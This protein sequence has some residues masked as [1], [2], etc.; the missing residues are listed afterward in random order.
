MPA[1]VRRL[2]TELKPSSYVLTIAPN[3]EALTFR[4]TV[5]VRLKKTGRPSQRITFHQHG[6]TVDTAR[7]T[8]FDKKGVHDVPVKRINNQK[9]LDEVRLHTDMMVYSGEYEVQMEFHGKILRNLTGLYPSYFNVDGKEHIL[10]TTQFESHYARQMFPCIDEPEAKAVFT[11]M[12]I[13]PEDDVVLS[14][15]PIAS[16]AAYSGEL[17]P[18]PAKALRSVTFQQTPRM[19][20]YLLAMAIG[21]MHSRSAKTVR[22][23]DVSVWGTIA[24][25]AE[26]FDFALDAAK[27]SIEFFESYFGVPY[28]L[29]KS[30]HLALPDFSSG[31][32]ENWGLIVYRERV[33]LAYPNEAA[34]STKETIAS[35]VAHEVS[36]QWFGNLV[37]MRWWNDL[38]LNESFANVM[39]YEAPATLF[40]E[41]NMWDEFVANEG[42]AAL[43]RDAQKGI[44]AIKT[45]V[46]HPDE[47]NTLFDP[48]IVYAKGGRLI[49]MLKTHI[50]EP[51]FQKGLAAY[52]KKHAYG[53]TAGNDLWDALQQSSNTD[54][55]AFMNPWIE[56]SNFPV[57][58]VTQTGRDVIIT[59]KHFTERGEGTDQRLWPVPLFAERSDLPD[60][61]DGGELH[62]KLASEDFV[63]LNQGSAGH[64]L[65]RYEIPEHRA[66]VASLVRGGKLSVSDRLM[67]LN[68]AAMLAKAGYQPFG[69]VLELLGAYA[70]E[71]NESVWGIISLVVSEARRFIDLDESLEATIKQF[72]GSLIQKQYARLGWKE[73]ESESS[74][75]QKLRATIIA[76]GV[77]AEDKAILAEALRRFAAYQQDASSLNPELRSIVMGAAVR[78]SVQSVT[79]ELL[80]LHDSTSNADLRSDI[81]A[82]LTVTERTDDAVLLLDRLTDP[83]LVKPQDADY[84]LF[85]L[86]RNRHTRAIAWDWMVAHWSWVM[87]TYSGDK[88]YDDFPRYTASACNTKAWADKYEAFFAPMQSDITL[89]RNIQVALSEIQTRVRWLQ[90][91]LASIQA[92]FTHQ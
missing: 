46:R 14:N 65:V 36:H 66:H 55:G 48:S 29:P 58:T 47:I 78:H 32:M 86:I 88:S 61:L 79:A 80:K 7:I 70:D 26:A 10:L 59:Q 2:Y 82:A 77:Y 40:P 16:E 44:Q 20:T 68:G 17:W 1:A 9:S 18:S 21:K 3:A 89:K 92:F 6:L 24:Q 31:A 50:G 33:L 27:R 5:T 87:E 56:Q 85:Y 64:Y 74:S 39:E 91:D 76:L 38:W 25:P 60:R 11:L 84:W 63:I 73:R 81:C 75:D 62:R 30:D 52:F 19:S 8:H 43:R 57:V 41:W 71:D 49:N 90:R 54:V 15:T 51:A 34:Q 22:G 69:E 45:E 67:L 12:V 83:K 23:T 28:P 37:T 13:A 4:G 35:V 72:V 53:N 42:I